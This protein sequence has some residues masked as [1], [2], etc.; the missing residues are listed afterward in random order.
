MTQAVQS[1]PA[2]E[3]RGS[4]AAPKVSVVT[5]FHNRAEMLVPSLTS[6]LAQ[7]LTDLQIILVDDGSTDE[8]G[9]ILRTI[10]DER[11]VV[12]T[13][14]N[15]GFTAS[16]NRALAAAR[17]PYVAIHGSGDISH[18]LRL[19]RQAAIL[20]ARPEVGVVGCAFDNAESH[21]EPFR[22]PTEVLHASFRRQMLERDP[23]THGSL[24]FRRS[25]L[26]EVGGYREVFTYAQ[27][28]D[29]LLRL[30]E[31]CG[32]HI[33]PEVLYT[34]RQPANAVNRHPVKSL[35][36]TYFV[37]LAIQCAQA[38]D[39]QGQD[40]VDRYG[41]SALLLR[42]PSPLLA[43]KLLVQGVR[44]KVYGRSAVAGVYLE[45]CR[46]ER[47]AWWVGISARLCGGSDSGPVWRWLIGPALRKVFDRIARAR[48]AERARSGAPFTVEALPTPAAERAQ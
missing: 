40:L 25:L 5:V 36:Q 41:S 44:A 43:R 38:R 10:A 31:R 1:R 35:L 22:K 26:V 6:L 48:T 16:L 20:D 21:N 18:P 8:T 32:Y 46:R 33:V 14:N 34:R 7:S 17:A 12:V 23:F 24:M 45:A 4:G 15:L 28:R 27:D 29:L 19:E 3:A 47:P 9:E 11:L 13:Q 39:A 42:R 30:S 2:G 37:E